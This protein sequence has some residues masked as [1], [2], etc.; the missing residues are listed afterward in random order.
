MSAQARSAR[1]HATHDKPDRCP[2]CG[3]PYFARL[4]RSKTWAFR[5]GLHYRH[6]SGGHVYLHRIGGGR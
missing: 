3:R 5:V 4:P 2:E 1:V 6:V